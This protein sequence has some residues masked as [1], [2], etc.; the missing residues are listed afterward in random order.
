MTVTDLDWHPH[1]TSLAETVAA[2]APAWRD[3]VASMPRHL[4]VPRWWNR[5]RDV[6]G[7]WTLSDGPASPR[8]WMNA[9]YSDT[10]LVTRAGALHADHAGDGQ[11]GIGEPTSSSTMPG[12]VVTM[13]RLLDVQPGMTAVDVAT[14]SGYS[15]ALLSQV[16]GGNAVLSVDVDPY[17][18]QAAGQRLAALGIRPSIETVDATGPLPAD[19][20]DRLV[21]M[22]SA[23]GIPASWLTAVRPGG[24]LVTTIANTSLMVIAE[25]HTDG[26]ATGRIAAEQGH[27]MTVRSALDY[28]TRLPEGYRHAREAEGE[29]VTKGRRPLPD[30]WNEPDL[31]MIFELAAPNTV[32]QTMERDGQRM[33]WLFQD[34]G[35]WA[36]ATATG[37]ELPVI[38]QSGPRR[39]WTEL[40]QAEARWDAADRFDLRELSASFAPDGAVLTGPA[41][42]S[43][44]L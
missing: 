32:V 28:P 25:K 42:W 40:E 5:S 1:A 8:D 16:L 35:S 41:G 43:V 29:E 34:D 10:T 22:V 14:G 3:A 21:A 30:W 9:A 37:D 20:F 19:G 39:L 31:S 26:T 17:L 7:G 2:N 24:R 12:L 13:L 33:L 36:R 38:H 44:H 27:F 15:A 23:R 11:T 18:T 6:P 4:L